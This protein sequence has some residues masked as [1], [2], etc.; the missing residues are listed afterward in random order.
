MS[1]E[2]TKTEVFTITEETE[3]RKT[4][5]RRCIFEKY[6][7]PCLAELFGTGLFVFVGCA[8]VIGNVGTVGVIQP[9]V[10]HGLALGVLIMVF[11]QISGGHFNPAVSLMAY[12]CGGMEFLLLLPYILAQMVG[13]MA[14]AGLTKAI[15][16]SGVYTASL[17]GA[18][19]VTPNA[20][21]ET[22][23]AEVIMTTFL[24]TVV[25]MGAINTKTSSP[26]APFCIGLTVTAN[27][28]AGAMISG[29]C[30]NPARAFGPAVVANHWSHHWIY[31]VGPFCG[32]LVT[33]SFIRLL[34]G[35]Q[36]TRLVLK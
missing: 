25:C 36:K 4:S 6:V 20:L 35:D 29:A 2:E 30:M 12:L 18:F 15:Y 23:L 22:T 8:S 13:G 17:G 5:R 7:Q 32:A 11:G 21:A 31:W 19:G 14:G 28:F 27:I 33:A 34:F 26:W 10:A 16:P 3:V 9:A 1:G 24:T